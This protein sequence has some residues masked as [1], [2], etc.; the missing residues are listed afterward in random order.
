MVILNL[1]LQTINNLHFELFCFVYFLFLK[2]ICGH[3]Q[4]YY[5]RDQL[6]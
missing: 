2:L 6:E 5:F 1:K 4:L 3:E